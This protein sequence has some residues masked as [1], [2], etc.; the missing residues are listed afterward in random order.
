MRF[1]YS[2][3]EF[4]KVRAVQFGVL[5]PDEI[6]IFLH[7]FPLSSKLLAAR[8]PFSFFLFLF[9]FSSLSPGCLDFV[10]VREIDQSET[11][12]RGKPKR[13]GLADPRLGAMDKTQKCDTCMGS[14]AEC[15]G[16]FGHLELAKPMFHTGFMRT[17]L[18]V[19][20]CVCFSCSRILS[21]EVL[22]TL[23]FFQ[24]F[25]YDVWNVGVRVC[26]DLEI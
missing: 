11:M 21:D 19:L 22:P 17:V 24:G 7:R 12:K 8:F 18:T 10:Y 14:M 13:G 1:P 4:A 25:N 16:H 15:P 20:R 3:A 26:L 5:S 6:V 2:P 9:L 23:N